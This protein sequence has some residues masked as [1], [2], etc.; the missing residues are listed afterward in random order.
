M[1]ASKQARRRL[2]FC[3]ALSSIL[4]L[5]AAAAAVSFEGEREMG[6]Q[7]DLALRRSVPILT[8]PEVE[9]YVNGIGQR[10]TSGL[11]GS[12]FD[13]RFAVVRDPNVN[14]FAVPGGYIY[15]H[16]G[17]LARAGSDD[18]VAAVLGHEAAHVHAH[19]LA[20]QQEATQL[21]NY[22]T[23]LGMLASIVQPAIGTLVTG[24]STA[25]SLKYRREFEQEADYLGVRYMRQA[26]YEPRAMLD[27]FKKL[28]DEQRTQPTMVPPYLQSHPLTDQRL[29]QLEAVLRSPQWAPRE[30]TS[31]SF[32][33]LRVQAIVRSRM[34]PPLDVVALYRR[35]LE[36]EPSDPVRQYLFGLAALEAHQVDAAEKPLHDALA[37][38]LAAAEREIG[39]LALRRRDAKKA[40]ELLERYVESNPSDARAQAELGKALQVL[41]ET[42][43]ALAAYRRALALAPD[44]EWAHAEA[45]LLAGRSGNEA[46]GFYH[47][48]TAARLSGDYEKSLSQYARAEPLLP[49]G[50]P[51][52]VEVRRSMEELSGFLRVSAPERRPSP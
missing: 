45:G 19:H 9:S 15:L 25:V 4:I 6:R 29:N 23:L 38:G 43:P 3:A 50:D 28:A 31:T 12:M 1:A 17:L 13:Y 39:R 16:S 7:F 32:E 10:I 42:E 22:A 27:F 51:R 36:E 48:A 34:G 46:E 2:R 40:R 18:E 35:W 37:G 20:R 47:L 26:G 44:F 21:L 11:D 33:L 14:A 8:D 24:A 52:G 41:G 5:A 30:K 49:A